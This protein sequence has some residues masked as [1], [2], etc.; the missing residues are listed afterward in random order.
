MKGMK[1]AHDSHMHKPCFFGTTIV[2][3]RGQAVIPAEAREALKLKKGDKLLVFGMGNGMLSF[4]TL[5]GFEKFQSHMTK[6][7][8]TIRNVIKKNS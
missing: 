4:S 6:Q 3:E 8:E 1:K 2:G 7:L 5:S